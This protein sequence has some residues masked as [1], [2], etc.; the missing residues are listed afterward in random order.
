MAHFRILSCINKSP[1]AI[2][3]CYFGL[4]SNKIHQLAFSPLFLTVQKPKDKKLKRST[5]NSNNTITSLLNPK[6]EAYQGV[7]TCSFSLALLNML[8]CKMICH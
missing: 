2:V 6:T 4:S 8:T 1:S 5:Q 3:N 7:F